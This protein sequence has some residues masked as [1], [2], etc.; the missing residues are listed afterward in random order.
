MASEP[1]KR[2]RVAIDAT[3]LF[4]GSG[5][6]RWPY[7]VLLAGLRGDIQLV[8]S[9]FVIEQARRSLGRKYPQ[10]L[11]RFEKFLS[12]APLEIVPEATA[13]EIAQN[14]GLVRDESDLPVVLPAINAHVDY[15]VS[16]DKDL[17]VQD[18]TTEKL[19][20][21]LTVLLSGTFL[22]E[23]MGWTSQDLEMIRQ[24]QWS[25]LEESAPL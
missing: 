12:L 3:V 23:V 11:P 1:A 24:R 15:L 25:D 5:W 16:E 17:T 14:Q 9:P 13:E 19:R 21:K 4:A 18:E 10:H 2:L 7:E 6:P 22:R 20:Q 8:V